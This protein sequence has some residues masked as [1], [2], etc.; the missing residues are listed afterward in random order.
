MKISFIKKE[1]DDSWKRRKQNSLSNVFGVASQ[2]GKKY[3]FFDEGSTKII[4]S[5]VPDE[6]IYN[7]NDYGKREFDACL[8]IGD[9]SGIYFNII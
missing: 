2:L 4:A 7:I 1:E 9:V 8:M 3:T 5:L 6:V